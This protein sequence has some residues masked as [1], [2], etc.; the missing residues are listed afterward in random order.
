M[1]L[2]IIGYGAFGR[3]LHG[4]WRDL[5][6]VRVTAVADE[7]PA[8]DPG[9]VRFYRDWR[10]LLADP[11]VD[12]I[13][14]ATPPSTHAEIACEAMLA[15]K[16]V[17]VEKPL[18]TSLADADRV[19]DVQSRTG[20]VATVDFMLRFN[21][22]VEALHSWCRDGSFG[23]LRRVVVENYAQDETLGPN[24]WFWNSDVSG[25]IL[26]EHAVHFLDI[27]NGCTSASVE[28]V[29]GLSISRN[30]RLQDRMMATVAYAD[31][32]VAT[33]FHAFNRPTFFE[34]TSMR[35]VFD[36]AQLDVEGWI[37]MEGTVHALVSDRTRAALTRLP[38]LNL[39]QTAA[40]TE[41]GEKG[42]EGRLLRSG[43][44]R[45]E[46]RDEVHATFALS[47]TKMDAYV[48]ALRALLT[49]VM[50]GIQSP[51]H[52]LRVTLED[53][54]RSLALAYRSSSAARSITETF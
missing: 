11:A 46:V 31:G 24:H 2:A 15:G 28:Q 21:P 8:R 13:S 9:G 12:I 53:G 43:G 3:F 6:G 52:R 18:A 44:R 45:Y 10:R 4:A 40:I 19:L 16:H 41:A 39:L 48:A 54:K 22:I 30:E 33:H 27:V 25:G 50:A 47:G 14:V 1:E 7:N 20:L 51:S 42:T 35:F 5:E 38:N 49:D 32:L 17:L 26:I 36:L 23:Q 29:E 34:H 37:P